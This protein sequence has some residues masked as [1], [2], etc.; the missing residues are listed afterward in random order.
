MLDARLGKW[1]SRHFIWTLLGIVLLAFLLR[2]GV[3]VELSGIEAVVKPEYKSDMDNYLRLMRRIWVGDW[4]DHF[5]YQP[6]YYTVFLPLCR[7]LGGDN[8]WP[9]MILQC[10]L[11]ACT[12]GLTGLCAAK[13]FGRVAG[14][15]SALLL[16]LYNIHIFFTPFAL[17]EV[18][19]A[20]WLILLFWLGLL[21]LKQ[22]RWWQWLLTGLVLSLATLT[23]GNALLL[24]PVFLAALVWRNKM[25]W[26]TLG[27]TVAFILVFTLPRLPFSIRN[28]HWAGR[29]VGPSTAGERVLL[30][31][32]SPE[33]PAGQLMYPRTYH[34]WTIDTELRPEQGRVSATGRIFKWALQEPLLFLDL[35]FRKC[36]L[37]WNKIEISHNVALKDEGGTSR[38]LKLPFLLPFAV[39]VFFA[40]SGLFLERRFDKPAHLLLL[41]F[42]LACWMGTAMFYILSRFR[43]VTLPV[44][45]IYGGYAIGELLRLPGRL[46]TTNSSERRRLLVVHGGVALLAVFLSGSAYSLWCHYVLPQLLNCERPNGQCLVFEKQDCAILR[47]HG[48]L[49]EPQRFTLFVCSERAPTTVVKRFV[50]PP[51]R[52]GKTCYVHLPVRFTE[53]PSVNGILKV[54]NQFYQ[55]D[56]AHLIKHEDDTLAFEVKV[57]TMPEDGVFVFR[58]PA[59]F[60]LPIDET[61]RYRRT[62]I[63][64]GDEMYPYI[65]ELAME[66]GWRLTDESPGSESGPRR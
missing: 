66:L 1:L 41:F 5:E 55:L 35:Q 38:I 59:H 42:L 49:L 22:N 46:K 30:I 28:Y 11:G 58:F 15:F 54:G 31:G 34:N 63:Y 50:I 18:L 23:R 29:W 25:H 26:R 40:L 52:V 24:L 9:I 27:L 39:V 17:Y 36:L 33:A 48:P 19:Q 64:I 47:D 21:C 4:P 60:V 16:A 6:F 10:L 43:L 3:C 2:L 32:N 14:L 12:V 8:P 20:F 45:C 13:L 37:F 44:I 57:D 7:C 53:Q 61:S 56:G 65:G 62:E 51:S